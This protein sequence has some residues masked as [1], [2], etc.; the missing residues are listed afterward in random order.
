M[1]MEIRLSGNH[2]VEAS[3]KGFL[4]ATDQP[5]EHGGEASAPTPFDLFLASI[6]TCMGYY[7]QRFCAARNLDS[8][9]LALTLAFDRGRDGKGIEAIRVAVELPAEFPA[10]YRRALRAAIEGCAVKRQMENPPHVSVEVAA[11]Q[12]EPVLH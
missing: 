5:L 4:V 3:Y 2:R 7:A 9:G 10:M 8:D 12:L 6:G 1:N 11:C